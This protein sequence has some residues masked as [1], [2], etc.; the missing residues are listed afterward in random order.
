M[1][2]VGPEAYKLK[3]LNNRNSIIMMELLR[4]RIQFKH[5]SEALYVLAVMFEQSN[6]PTGGIEKS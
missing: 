5:F 2:T 3:V 4:K 1:E 6:R